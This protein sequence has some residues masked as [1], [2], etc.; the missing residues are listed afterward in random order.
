MYIIL[1]SS[2]PEDKP[3]YDSTKVCPGEPFIYSTWVKGYA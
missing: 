1:S 3:K 2:T